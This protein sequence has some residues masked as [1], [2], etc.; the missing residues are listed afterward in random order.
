[1]NHSAPEPENSGDIAAEPVESVTATDGQGEH[2]VMPRALFESTYELFGW[3]L[4]ADQ[5][6]PQWPTQDPDQPAWPTTDPDDTG[7]GPF[8]AYLPAEEHA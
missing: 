5:P 7:R 1:M 4:V 6:D 8:D 2:A 3:A